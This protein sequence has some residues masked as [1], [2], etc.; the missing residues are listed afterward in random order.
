MELRQLEYFRAVSQLGSITKAAQHLHIAQPSISV[1]IQKL[2]EELGVVLFDRS[3]RQIVLT[4]EGSIFENHVNGIL[5]G[6]HDSIAEMKD[7]S[8][9]QKG[10]IR[11]GVP[12]MVGAFLFSHIFVQFRKAYPGL[13]INAQESGS[14][15]IMPQLEKGG[16]D[17]GI[18]TIPNTSHNL[19]IIPLT[20]RQFM[21]CMAYGHHLSS[22]PAIPFREL[23]NEPFV[24]LE[25]DSYSRHI[26]LQECEKYQFNPQIIF[27]SNQMETVFDSVEQNVGISFFLDVIAKKHPT[28]L[29]RPLADPLYLHIAL[30]WNKNRYLSN[31]VKAFINFVGNLQF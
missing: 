7:L 4:A 12:P 20:T 13:Q 16:L 1:S 21:V 5:T 3:Q 25:A 15:S 30:A 2:E 24:L 26:I 9:L 31:A 23:A 19:E 28:I 10:S 27:T 14:L 11:L 18:I 6:V 29:A 22:L 8:L 17:V